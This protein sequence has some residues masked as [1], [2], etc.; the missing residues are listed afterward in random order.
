MEITTNT[1]TALT[2]TKGWHLLT[3]GGVF[4]GATAVLEF[5]NGSGVWEQVDALG[6]LTDGG[7]VIF[8]ASQNCAYRITTSGGGG[9]LNITVTAELV[10]E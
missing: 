5:D 1:S 9:S 4:D 6:S 10:P 7:Q 8:Y 2:V 3:A